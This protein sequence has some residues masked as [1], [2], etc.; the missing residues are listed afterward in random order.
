[1][2]EESVIYKDILRKGRRQGKQEGLLQGEERGTRKVA[3]R[4]LER[5]FGK[6]SRSVLGEIEALS[7]G[8]LE[9]LCDALLD[10]KSKDD[11]TR[12]LKKQPRA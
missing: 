12:W 11:L 8:R 2:L 9:M 6:L 7:V 5:R 10:F 1:M 3:T 4:Q